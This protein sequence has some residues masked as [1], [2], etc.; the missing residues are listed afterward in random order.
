MT[1][2]TLKKWPVRTTFGFVKTGTGELAAA[3]S[4]AIGMTSPEVDGSVMAVES[5]G[6]ETLSPKISGTVT[7]LGGCSGSVR[8][9][10]AEAHPS[11][12]SVRSQTWMSFSFD[13]T[14][15]LKL[16]EKS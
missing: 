14:A 6:G 5:S 10:A 3:F 9:W 2:T 7:S 12:A 16:Y 11:R 4:A 13:V 15:I 1:K 8:S